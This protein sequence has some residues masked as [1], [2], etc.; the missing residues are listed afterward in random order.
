MRH[1]FNRAAGAVGGV[2]LER[3]LRQI[4]ERHKITFGKK[5]PGISDL[6]DLLKNNNVIEIPQWRAIQHL[7]DLRNVCDH[8]KKVDPT[9]SEDGLLERDRVTLKRSRH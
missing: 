1:K 5:N 4:C 6:N 8:D 9:A 3:H 2:V 7:A